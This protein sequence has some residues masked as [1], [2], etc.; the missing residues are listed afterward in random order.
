MRAQG[1][2]ARDVALL[3]AYAHTHT[4]I[5]ERI[6]TRGASYDGG[7]ELTRSCRL[8]AR[9]PTMRGAKKRLEST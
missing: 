3:P 6:Y 7:L 4:H 2:V 5:Y 9:G 8:C 1:Q